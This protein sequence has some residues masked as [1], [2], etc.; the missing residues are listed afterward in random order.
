MQRLKKP[1][2]FQE[3]CY[4]DNEIGADVEV[5]EA[6][7]FEENQDIDHAEDRLATH[8][9]VSHQALCRAF[10]E[11]TLN[12]Q[13]AQELSQN[14]WQEQDEVGDVIVGAYRELEV[15]ELVSHEKGH[16]VQCQNSEHALVFL[17][18]CWR[19]I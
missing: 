2:Y 12:E 14:H 5:Q 3:H 13:E 9:F 10:K 7:H 16:N 18:Q 6:N 8:T 17:A 15:S 11:T 19:E 4:E 1:N